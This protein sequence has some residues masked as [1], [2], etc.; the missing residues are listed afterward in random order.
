M[1]D[2]T[3]DDILQKRARPSGGMCC[4]CIHRHASCGWLDFEVMP[5]MRL[6][7]DGRRVVRC[8][9]FKSDSAKE[10]GK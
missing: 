6:D 8:T 4:A 3:P 1:A 7:K 10:S 9:E 2:Q 5:T